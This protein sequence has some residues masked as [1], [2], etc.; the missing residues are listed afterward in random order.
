MAAAILVSLRHRLLFPGCQ[1]AIIGRCGVRS[2]PPPLPVSGKEEDGDDDDFEQYEKNEEQEIISAMK[3]H[4]KAMKFK[5][6]QRTMEPPGPPE[7][8]LTWNAI[9]QIRYLKQEF[10][11]EWTLQRLALGFNVSTD[12]IRRVLKSKFV[13]PEKRKMKQ[14]VA[15]SRVLGQISSGP[16]QES[17]KLM[18]AS[19]DAVEPLLLQGSK[20]RKLLAD[21]SSQ[22]LPALTTSDYSQLVLRLEAAVQK[23]TASSL[24]PLA[25]GQAPAPIVSN[26]NPSPPEAG[27]RDAPKEDWKVLEESWDGEVL[28]DQELEKLAYAG[29]EN[30]MKVVQKGSE[31]FDSDGNFLYSI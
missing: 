27:L 11:E 31:F 30:K 20:E 18:A 24:V 29:L 6:M 12:V 3:K 7:R 13:P 14:D 26:V 22:H 10:P 4:Q 1:S 21:P 5:R 9:E 25:T 28:D 15:V 16:H 19:T 17:A 8:H 23:H 2:R